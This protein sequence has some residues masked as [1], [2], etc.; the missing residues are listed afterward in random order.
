[1]MKSDE[2]HLENINND[3]DNNSKYNIIISI[4]SINFKKLADEQMV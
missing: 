2:Y 3:Y 4:F 1:M